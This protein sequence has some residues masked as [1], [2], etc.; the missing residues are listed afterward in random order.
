MEKNKGIRLLIAGILLF[1]IS[2]IFDRQI[3]LFF[4]DFRFAF[5]DIIF[6]VMTNF[7]V[8]VLVMLIIPSIILY[9]K[10]KKSVYLAW[11]TFIASVILAFVIKLIVLR[12]RPIE[13][14]AYPFITIINYSFPSMH[15]MAVFSLLPALIRFLP[16]QK[17]L[18]IGFAFLVGFTRIYFGFHFLSDVVFGALFGYFTGIFLLEYYEKGKSCRK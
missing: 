17:N 11:L 12:Q 16:K 5:F 3:N 8:A 13:A 14:F 2:Y 1:L 10:N 18:W 4:K 9:N 7:G 15:A 6:G